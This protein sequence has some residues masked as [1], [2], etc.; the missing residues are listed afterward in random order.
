MQRLCLSPLTVTDDTIDGTLFSA[1]W[2]L[3]GKILS[4]KGKGNISFNVAEPHIVT[5][6]DYYIEAETCIN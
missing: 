4:T 1:L 2:C 5:Q 3:T 6:S